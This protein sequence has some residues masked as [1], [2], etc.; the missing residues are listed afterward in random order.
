MLAETGGL[1]RG[2]GGGVGEDGVGEGRQEDERTMEQE[3]AQG[4]DKPLHNTISN[5]KTR[6][7]QH[8]SAS[9]LDIRIISKYLRHKN[10]QQVS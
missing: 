2:P 1:R 6:G 3:D 7:S 5:Q 10:N 9:I 4:Q 8:L